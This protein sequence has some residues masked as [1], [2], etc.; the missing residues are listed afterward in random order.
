MKKLS[1]KPLTEGP[2][3]GHHGVF[4]GDDLVGYVDA[5]E[6]SDYARE[7]LDDESDATDAAAECPGQQLAERIG[8]TPTTTFDE[9]RRRLVVGADAE[10]AS[11]RAVLLSE[12]ARDGVLD[13]GKAAI[14]AREGRITLADYIAAQEADR[15]LDEAVRAGKIL[16]R[17]RKFFFRDALDRPREF[18]E[19]VRHAAP[20][21]PLGSL[22]LASGGPLGVDD[23]VKARTES[24]MVEQNLSY[25]KALKKVFASDRELAGRYHTAH[26]RRLA[27]DAGAESPAE[28]ITQ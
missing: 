21:V 6:F 14:L 1:L 16:P 7:H 24:L 20:R 15:T 13:N 5:D 25:S 4:D 8:V 28:G 27:G 22:G 9:L 18:A 2:Q 3:S 12:A 23:E 26:R 11:A 10:A 19:Y 17:D